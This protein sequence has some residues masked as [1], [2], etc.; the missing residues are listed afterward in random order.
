MSL[1]PRLPDDAH[2]HPQERRYSLEELS[3]Q[4][5]KPV[6][7]IQDCIRRCEFRR[8]VCLE[9]DKTRRRLHHY[10]LDSVAWLFKDKVGNYFSYSSGSILEYFWLV[11]AQKLRT[12]FTLPYP[13]QVWIPEDEVRRFEEI[14]NLIPHLQE[15]P[16]EA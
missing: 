10:Y 9:W 15:A 3:Q 14:N 7:Y 8:V 11:K 1:T 16:L 5:N 13:Q 12:G 4:W 6:S 2:P